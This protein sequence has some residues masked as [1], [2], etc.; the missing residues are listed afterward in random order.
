MKKEDIQGL[1]EY[2]KNL[3]SGRKFFLNT[4]VL[5]VEVTKEEALQ[6][7]EKLLIEIEKKEGENND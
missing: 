6:H 3:P 7:L 5:M 1:I 4:G 2:V